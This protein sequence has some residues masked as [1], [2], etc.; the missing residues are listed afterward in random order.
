[1]H[2]ALDYAATGAYRSQ[3]NFQRFLQVRRDALEALG[4]EIDLMD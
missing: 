1:M 2:G 4:L 3:P